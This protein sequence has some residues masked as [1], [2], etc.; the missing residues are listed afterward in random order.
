MTNY[1]FIKKMSLP[2]MAMML[3]AW[4]EPHISNFSDETKEKAK[5]DIIA[6]LNEEKGVNP[7][8]EV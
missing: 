7:F 3:Y 4:I 6:F 5:Q 2:E 1:E 8:K